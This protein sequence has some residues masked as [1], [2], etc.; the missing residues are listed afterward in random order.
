M[1][2]KR[3]AAAATIVAGCAVLVL[4]LLVG[5]Y[6]FEFSGEYGPHSGPGSATFS[7]TYSF[8]PGTDYRTY[9]SCS[10]DAQFCGGFNPTA[11]TGSHSYASPG[12]RFVAY[13]NTGNLY[14]AVLGLILASAVLALLG[15]LAAFL[16]GRR[17]RSTRWSAILVGV[18]AAIALS[19][20]IAVWA[21]TP[22]TTGQDYHTPP[23]SESANF[24]G[25][26]GS[27]WGS[28]STASCGAGGGVT[29]SWGPMIGWY[30]PWLSALLLGAGAALL[31]LGGR[32]ESRELTGVGS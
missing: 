9:A 7:G 21:E 4:S 31:A 17:N 5:W 32:S 19:A 29:D 14:V 27:F 26:S 11:F 20:P 23:N 28:C 25:P 2:P 24:T 8:Y 16:L 6:G 18:A 3:I 13:P 30:L 22:T 12:P 15:L 10:G 1:K